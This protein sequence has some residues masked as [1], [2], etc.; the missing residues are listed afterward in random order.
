MSLGSHFEWCA[1]ERGRKFGAPI[2]FREGGDVFGC[3]LC[4]GTDD[5]VDGRGGKE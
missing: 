3:N 4:S 1:T 5:G 2:F